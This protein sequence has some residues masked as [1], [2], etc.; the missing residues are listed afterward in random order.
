MSEKD[1][2]STVATEAA[3]EPQEEAVAAQ[4]EVELNGDE[5]FQAAFEKTIVSI[6]P[7][8]VVVGKVVQLTE[9]EVCLNIGYKSDGIIPKNELQNPEDIKEQFQIGD[10]VEVEVIKV[11]DGEGNVLLSQRSLQVKKNWDKL[12]AAA[13]N[14]EYIEGVGKE[15]V[16][17]GLIVN[18]DGVR[19]FV[20]A[21]Q[22]SERYVEKIDQFVGQAMRLKIIEVDKHKKRLVASRK[23]V[24]I[25]EAAEKSAKVWESLEEGKVV[26]GIVR[27]LTDFGAFVDLGGV[28]GLIHVT[29]L[30]WARVRHPSDIVKPNQEVDVQV[31][32]LDREKERI[33]LGLKQLMPKPWDLAPEK[34]PVGSIV[35][36]KVVRIVPFGAFVELEPGLDGLVHISQVSPQRIGRV[37]EV[38]SIGDLILV[39]VLD[40]NTDT[41]RISLSVR[42]A[43][44]Y[45]AIMDDQGEFHE[46]QEEMM[47]EE[48]DEE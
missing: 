15:V 25:E 37:E 34:Y 20:P 10:E 18:V 38:L 35:E 42:E 21:S 44:D 2:T 13:E 30:S 23:A 41:R 1:I 32:A 26:K 5:S 45:S 36:G 3:Q 12:V 48:A 14:N 39:K 31:L 7:G 33:S 16:K 27:R 19:T 17:G 9:D 6:R 24:I 4:S 47:A 46:E 43:Y 28:D 22:L 29:D 40:V 8:Q 11:N